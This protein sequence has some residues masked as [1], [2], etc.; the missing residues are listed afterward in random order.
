M[1]AQLAALSLLLAVVPAVGLPA[2][3]HLPLAGDGFTFEQTIA[4]SGGYG[5]YAGYTETDAIVGTL[6]VTA[7][8]ATN[9]TDSA[10]FDY[11]GH[12]V[13]SSGANYDWVS[14]GNF[15]FSSTTFDYLHGTDNQ[16][17]DNGSG[18]WFYMNNSLTVGGVLSPLFTPMTVQSLATSYALDTTAGSDVRTIYADGI[19]AYERDDSYGLFHAVYDWRAYFDPSTGYIVAYDYTELDDDGHGDGFVYVES[20]A[21]TN[22]TYPLTPAPA[23][24]TYPVTFTASGLSSGSSWTVTFDG[25]P[26]SSTATTIV[27]PGV[28]NGTYLFEVSASGYSS[29]P[30]VSFLNVTGHAAGAPVVF[31]AT[32]SGSPADTILL[33]VLLFV[34]IVVV[35]GIIAYLAARRSR[36]SRPLPRHSF[37]GRPQYAP[38][39]P[40]APPPPISLRPSDQPLIQQVVVKEV[41]KVPCRYCG[42]LID[43]TA[44]KCLFCGATRT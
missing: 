2:A 3:H 38:I 44:E 12:Y 16:T 5:S 18:V 25:V 40:G 31:L 6:N 37:G 21:V 9:G 10:R 28:A 43:S 29:N 36:A 4:V 7:A 34:V 19:G 11:A 32:S 22:T 41:V 8:N 23:P 1:L 13:N 35:V 42:S 17:G 33:L 14:R 26:L 30:S 39:P 27:F 24:T 15:T 20:L